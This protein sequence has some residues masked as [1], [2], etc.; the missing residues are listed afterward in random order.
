M[1]DFKSFFQPFK[2]LIKHIY[3]ES[4][5]KFFRM[6]NNSETELMSFPEINRLLKDTQDYLNENSLEKFHCRCNSYY[7]FERQLGKE[8]DLKSKRMSQNLDIKCKNDIHTNQIATA[9]FLPA[10]THPKSE[11]YRH[12]PTQE[13]LVN[14]VNLFQNL[15]DV[16]CYLNVPTKMNELYYKYGQLKNFKKAIQNIFDP[17]GNYSI[18]R[19]INSVQTIHK[20]LNEQLSSSL[21][22]ILKTN[23]LEL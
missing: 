9:Q 3:P 11:Y 2:N 12:K 7:D 18:E 19:L 6:K 10:S 13:C 8:I 15:F 23:N 16:E 14:C 5:E 22:K 4:E 1:L 21:K 20:K 17:E